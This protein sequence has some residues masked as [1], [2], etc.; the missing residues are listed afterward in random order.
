M[1]LRPWGFKILPEI[2]ARGRTLR[3]EEVAYRF[4]PRVK[5]KS[6]MG[7]ME[8]LRYAGLLVRLRRERTQ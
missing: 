7:P 6:K 8:M 5:G 3:I 4:S 2:L 1:R